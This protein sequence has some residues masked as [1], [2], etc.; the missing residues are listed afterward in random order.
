MWIDQRRIIAIAIVVAL[1]MGAAPNAARAESGGD[2]GHNP[3]VYVGVVLTNI[4]YFPTKVVF[5]VLGGITGTLAY[6]VTIGDVQT[7]QAIWDSAC[8]GTYVVN[9]A[10][11]EGKEEIH[12]RGP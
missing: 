9:P 3:M 7:T 2:E 11:L 5:S 6:A 12:F 8:R 1:L 10:M 4:V